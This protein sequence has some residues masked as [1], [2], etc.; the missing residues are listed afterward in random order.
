MACFPLL[1]FTQS[2]LRAEAKSYFNLFPSTYHSRWSIG[3]CEQL[4]IHCI[5]HTSPQARKVVQ[6]LIINECSPICLNYL[7][8]A[9]VFL[10]IHPNCKVL[11]RPSST[12]ARIM[13]LIPATLRFKNPPWPTASSPGSSAKPTASVTGA[14]AAA[15]TFQSPFMYLMPFDPSPEPEEIAG[16]TSYTVFTDKQRRV[17]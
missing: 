9:K 5:G 15:H 8:R 11:L 7:Q 13:Y 12:A 2:P 14:A 16:Q 1:F 4:K 3:H 6:L 10:K 17:N